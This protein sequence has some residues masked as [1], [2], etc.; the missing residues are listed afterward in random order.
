MVTGRPVADAE[1]SLSLA[2]G[3]KDRNGQC[4][5][6]DQRCSPSRR[7]AAG[8]PF[9]SPS[10]IQG[11]ASGPAKGYTEALE[12]RLKETER[13]LW[14]LLSASP[15]ETLSAAFAAEMQD[16][17]PLSLA[18]TTLCTTEEKKAAI[19][20]WERFPLQTAGEVLAWKENVQ[21]GSSSGSGSANGLY[22]IAPDDSSYARAEPEPQALTTTSGLG[23]EEPL[24]AGDE[25]DTMQTSYSAHPSLT[26]AS[27]PHS[28]TNVGEGTIRPRQSATGG[29][30]ML[31]TS[32]NGLATD[33]GSVASKFG[34]SK[35]FQETFLW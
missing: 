24:P 5:D 21:S 8:P 16:R 12:T 32:A 1:V 31:D 29:S 11:N 7:R 26:S 35:E 17:M 2:C 18:I 22:N 4:L 33:R 19:A 13:V 27:S 20:H 23:F 28:H 25:D 14:S 3:R 10:D 15:T 9:H 30:S 6:P 34:L